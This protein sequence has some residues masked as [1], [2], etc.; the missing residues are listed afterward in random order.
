MVID[1][2]FLISVSPLPFFPDFPPSGSDIGCVPPST[3]G[4]FPLGG[5]GSGIICGFKLY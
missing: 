3:V 1:E 2:N 4:Y 5:V